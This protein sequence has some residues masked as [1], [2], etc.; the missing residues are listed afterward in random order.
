MRCRVRAGGVV[1]ILGIVAASHHVSIVGTPLGRVDIR[2]VQRG[3]EDVRGIVAGISIAVPRLFHVQV[4]LLAVDSICRSCRD[5]A[6][7]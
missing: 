2:V 4:R 3:A 7:T 6:S 5:H 1:V